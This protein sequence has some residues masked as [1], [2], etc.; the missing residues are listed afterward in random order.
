MVLGEKRNGYGMEKGWEK[1]KKGR[2]GYTEG[3]KNT[4]E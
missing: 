4:A 2:K 3:E 1:V